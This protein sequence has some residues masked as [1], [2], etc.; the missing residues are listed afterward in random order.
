MG[1]ESGVTIEYE[2]DTNYLVAS[3]SDSNPRDNMEPLKTGGLIS[4]NIKAVES[5]LYLVMWQNS[6]AILSVMYHSRGNIR[7]YFSS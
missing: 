5:G 2:G 7:P 6:T 3:G 4:I 1:A